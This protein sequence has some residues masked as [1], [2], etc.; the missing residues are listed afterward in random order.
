MS[1][2]ADLNLFGFYGSHDGLALIGLE[3]CPR[4][5]FV[6][7]RDT[8]D[9]RFSNPSSDRVLAVRLRVTFL[10]SPSTKTIA[11]LIFN[12]LETISSKLEICRTLGRL[13]RVAILC[14]QR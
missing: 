6:D 7:W 8:P 14:A 4:M 2:A 12:G 11:A 10:A 1:F 5:G 3:P 9:C 13:W